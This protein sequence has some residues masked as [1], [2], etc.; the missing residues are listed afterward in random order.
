MHSQFQHQ[1]LIQDLRP[2]ARVLE[3]VTLG[4][5]LQLAAVPAVPKGVLSP[6]RRHPVA[7]MPPENRTMARRGPLARGAMAVRLSGSD[8]TAQTSSMVLCCH[9]PSYH[10][11]F[12]AAE[13]SERRQLHINPWHALRER[14]PEKWTTVLRQN[15]HV[16]NHNSDSCAQ[17]G[18]IRKVPGS[19][20][21]ATA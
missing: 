7:L 8:L 13:G 20:W 3:E 1:H 15:R 9:P 12:I 11:A 17:E 6:L 4:S 18:T 2:C 5:R 21:Q 14:H 16:P 10:D 19:A